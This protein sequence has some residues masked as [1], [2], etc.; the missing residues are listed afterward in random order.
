M[1]V[2]QPK[3]NPLQQHPP[4]FLVVLADFDSLPLGKRRNQAAWKS[5]DEGVLLQDV[6]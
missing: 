6:S 4:Q 5:R 3:Y 1:L 2:L